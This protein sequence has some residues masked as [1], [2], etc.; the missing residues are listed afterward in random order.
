MKLFI[1]ERLSEQGHCT[2][3][4]PKCRERTTQ[5]RVI[6]N[7]RFNLNLNTGRASMFL[8]SDGSEFQSLGDLR[9]REEVALWRRSDRYRAYRHVGR[10]KHEET[11]Q[12]LTDLT[13]L[14]RVQM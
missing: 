14:H 4:Q 3:N 9:E 1:Y 11:T 5:S 6:V 10:V 13:T 7:G 12:T 2:N 8:M